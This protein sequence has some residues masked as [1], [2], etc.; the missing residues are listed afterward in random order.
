MSGE[1][2]DFQQ[3]IGIT[4]QSGGVASAEE[5][6]AQSDNIGVNVD[7]RFLG[8]GN[9]AIISRTPNI[10]SG[11]LV[12]QQVFFSASTA[13]PAEVSLRLETRRSTFTGT[14]AQLFT[15]ASQA[16]VTAGPGFFVPANGTYFIVTD[17]DSSST[18]RTDLAV[19]LRRV[20]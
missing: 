7:R 6:A 5:F 14:D 13:T 11:V 1:R 3:P 12:I 4:S 16:P 20:Q 15:D 8:A 9:G 17:N 19:V 18:V 10:S 2:P